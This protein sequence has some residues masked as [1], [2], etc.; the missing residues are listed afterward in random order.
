MVE[1]WA[2]GEFSERR[3]A[4]SG[5]FSEFPDAGAMVLFSASL[6]RP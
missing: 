6:A 4:R 2:G 1:A 3:Q 5:T